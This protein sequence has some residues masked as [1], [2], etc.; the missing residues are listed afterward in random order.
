MK[1]RLVATFPALDTA[2][3]NIISHAVKDKEFKVLLPQTE[4]T[5]N[6]L[7]ELLPSSEIPPA[8]NVVWTVQEAD[9]LSKSNQKLITK[10]FDSLET[11]HDQLAIASGLIGRLAC[12]LKPNQLM[13]VLKASI[14]PLIQLRTAARADIEAATS[15]PTELPK[16]QAERIEMLI[17]P[18]PNS[19][20]LRKEKN[21][22]SN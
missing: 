17:L 11:A 13:L 22:Q 2:N 7:E 18:D 16:K 19:P 9:T 3:V 10:L 14:R 20:Q 4:D 1:T 6:L 5:E 8:T 15:R 21:K 12:T